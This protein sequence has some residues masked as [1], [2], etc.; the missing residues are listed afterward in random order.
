M[1]LFA[2]QEVC[3]EYIFRLLVCDLLIE[4]ILTYKQSIQLRE[5][6]AELILLVRRKSYTF[7]DIFRIEERFC[8]QKPFLKASKLMQILFNALNVDSLNL[9]S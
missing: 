4:F 5:L 7:R 9:D 6:F 8:N 2:A 1:K 3:D